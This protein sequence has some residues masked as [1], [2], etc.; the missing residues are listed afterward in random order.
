MASDKNE[1]VSKVTQ[2]EKMLL[3]QNIQLTQTVERLTAAMAAQQELLEQSEKRIA[4]LTQTI[5]A[6]NQKIA[7]LT[8]QRNKNSRNSSKPP[9]TDGLSKPAPKSLRKSSGRKVGGQKGHKGTNFCVTSKPDRIVPHMPSS[10][11]GCPHFADCKARACVTEVRHEVDMV[12]KT[13]VVTHQALE[14]ECPLCREQRRG[15]F[16]ESIKSQMQYGNNLRAL[17]VALNTM[18][19][20]RINRVHEILGSVFGIPLSTGAISDW[21]TRFAGRITDVVEKIGRCVAGSPVAHFD[22]TGLRM[23]GKLHYAHVAS[24]REYTYLYFSAKRGY[25]AMDEGN[26]LPEFRGIAVHDCWRPYWH[27][28]Q[29]THSVCCA[30]LLRE[31]N[32]VKENHP[33]QV[34][35]HHFFDLLLRMKEAKEKAIEMGRNALSAYQLSA[36]SWLYDFFLRI[37]Q[38]ENPL[39]E[40]KPGQRGRLKKGKVLSLIERLKEYKGAVCLFAENFAVPFDN[41]QAERDLRMI[42]VKQKVSGCFRTKEGAENYLTI[43]SYVGTARKQGV[44]PFNAIRQAME[45]VS[46]CCWVR[47]AE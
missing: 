43:M 7:E 1:R 25:L 3:Q 6:L 47:G 11:Q 17:A 10:C 38:K 5:E 41:N 8:E 20:V 45:G 39:P 16:P 14:V 35:A 18:G 22:E 28:E 2:F 40:R 42:K 27:Y 24:T 34:W 30:H 32:G 36:F 12:I 29:A 9:S 46:C 15:E 13:E 44:N 4:E 21:V 23:N 19:A 37:G 31:L 33:K 26:V